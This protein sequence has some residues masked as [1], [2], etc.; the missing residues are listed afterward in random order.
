[1]E[2]KSDKQNVSFSVEFDCFS[3]MTA[4]SNLCIQNTEYFRF[5]KFQEIQTTNL[6]DRQP[7]ALISSQLENI[8]NRLNEREIHSLHKRSKS[9]T[10]KQRLELIADEPFEEQPET[11]LSTI[12]LSKLVLANLERIND[13]AN[14]KR[15]E[16][17]Y[18]EPP[19]SLPSRLTDAK[20]MVPK[21]RKLGQPIE[22]IFRKQKSQKRD[23]ERNVKPNTR[24][25]KKIK[26]ER[27]EYVDTPIE[28]E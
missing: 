14:H 25:Q 5:V 27:C 8:E 1:M 15:D 28:I 26:S 13:G 17:M 7:L 3:K 2:S 24:A 4:A 23:L 16:P 22:P 19:N 10:I 18:I 11:Q 20:T 21:Q 6:E 9:Q 12:C